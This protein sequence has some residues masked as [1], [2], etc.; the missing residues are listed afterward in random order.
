MLQFGFDAPHPGGK[1]SFAVVAFSVAAL[2]GLA[3]S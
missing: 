1:A 3:G 2:G